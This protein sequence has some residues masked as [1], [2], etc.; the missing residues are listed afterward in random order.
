MGNVKTLTV[1]DS[2][3]MMERVTRAVR[4]ESVG[5]CSDDDWREIWAWH[6][7]PYNASNGG[8]WEYIRVARAV[9]AELLE[10]TPVM[11]EAGNKRQ[12]RHGIAHQIFRDMIKTA[13]EM[14]PSRVL[15]AGV[16][17]DLQESS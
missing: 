6:T 11:V 1:A 17:Q 4:T 12:R 7:D 3:H 16:E 2:S 14:K 8:E 5:A 10:P 9:L 13:M 15:K